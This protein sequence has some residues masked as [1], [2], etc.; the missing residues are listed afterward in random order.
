MRTIF[1][2]GNREVIISRFHNLLPTSQRL[3]GSMDAP[4]MIAHLSDQM[5][6]T[7]GLAESNQYAGWR[8]NALVRYLAIYVIPWPKGRI[9]GPKDA[10]L[11]PPGDWEQDVDRLVSFIEEIASREKQID[12]PPHAMLGPMSRKDWGAFCYKHF[13]HHLRQ[14]GV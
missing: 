12:W 8:R 10:F 1:D 4:R 2:E 7:L 13:D 5:R 14:F 9:K 3:W 11:T 6:H